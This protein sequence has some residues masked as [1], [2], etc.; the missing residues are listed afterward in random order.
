MLKGFLD[1]LEL[2]TYL[3]FGVNNS[4]FILLIFEREEFYVIFS[5]DLLCFVFSI[6]LNG[7]EVSLLQISITI[8]LFFI[9]FFI[10]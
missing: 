4:P 10:F 5:F 6:S 2:N 3:H 7:V 1:E 8:F 9:L